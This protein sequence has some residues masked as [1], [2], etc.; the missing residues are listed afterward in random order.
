VERLRERDARAL[1]RPIHD[2]LA[3][4]VPRIQSFTVADTD[5]PPELDERAQDGWEALLAIAVAAAGHWPRL[6]QEAARTIFGRRHAV[7]DNHELRL[8]ADFKAIFGATDH[9]FLATVELREALLAIEDSPWADIRGKAISPHY[10]ARLLRRFEI[11]PRRHRPLG[12]GNPV[13]GYFRSDL[14][15]RWARY[16]DEESGTSGTNDTESTTGS[17]STADLVSVV[18]DVPDA[19]TLS[20]EEQRDLVAA[21]WDVFGDDIDWLP[22]LA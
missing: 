2:A 1:G 21:A 13:H 9:D 10:I 5:L 20:R 3:V 18:P 11:E 19:G 15:D 4:H 17:R 12:V 16:V 7:D 8:L 22:G 6:A 14:A